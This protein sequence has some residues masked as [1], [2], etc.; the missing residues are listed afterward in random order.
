MEERD[1]DQDNKHNDDDHDDY[2]AVDIERLVRKEGRS[3]ASSFLEREP[4]LR[5]RKNNTSQIAIVGA[6]VYPI[7]SLD[8]EYTSLFTF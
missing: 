6:N 3:N 8:Y 7:E 4:L 5:S 2:E 1:S